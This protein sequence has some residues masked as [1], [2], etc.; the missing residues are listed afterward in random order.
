MSE[1]RT[2][3]S[4]EYEG[5]WYDYDADRHVWVDDDGRVLVDADGRSV[6]PEEFLTPRP[7]PVD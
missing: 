3:L 2:G 7:G 1:R 6:W 4:L 5:R